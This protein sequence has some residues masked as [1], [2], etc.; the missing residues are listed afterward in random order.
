MKTTTV[1]VTQ[2]VRSRSPESLLQAYREAR[3]TE[4]VDIPVSSRQNKV[5]L[6]G[7]GVGYHDA[8]D[9]N[10][11]GGWI[12]SKY[13]PF[14]VAERKFLEARGV[15]GL[16]TEWSHSRSGLGLAGVVDASLSGGLKKYGVLENKVVGA[17]PNDG[18]VN[19]L[20]QLGCY[21]ELAAANGRR[22]CDQ[23]AVLCYVM[24]R[25]RKLRFLI[26]RDVRVLVAPLA[27]L[28]SA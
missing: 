13:F 16:Q 25:Q 26:W 9:A 21:C 4:A 3:E 19:D 11:Q 6:S 24:P 22:L 12:D 1:S 14:V 27:S 7:F 2:F 5:E 18:F 20:A 28:R 17:D 10:N 15:R 23:W 8:F